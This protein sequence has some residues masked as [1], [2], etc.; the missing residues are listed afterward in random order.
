MYDV[1]CKMYKQIF[2]N[3]PGVTT[4]TQNLTLLKD[5]DRISRIY[6]IIIK[7]LYSYPKNCEIVKYK[8]LFLH[9]SLYYFFKDHWYF[10]PQQCDHNF[11]CKDNIEAWFGYKRMF[12]KSWSYIAI[13]VPPVKPVMQQRLYR[14][15]LCLNKT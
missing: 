9:K 3:I 2:S 7:H 13:F 12:Q 10:M 14:C 1:I 5:W 11:K 8:Y 4:K 6:V 15:I